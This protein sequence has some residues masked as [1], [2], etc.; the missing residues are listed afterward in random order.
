[1]T[2]I[3]GG[4]WTIA[5]AAALLLGA[6]WLRTGS[7]L[8]LAA[9]AL[10]A[11]WTLATTIHER[12]SPTA[13]GCAAVLLVFALL[14]G[15]DVRRQARFA[16]DAAATRTAL[17]QRATTDLAGELGREADRLR[18]LAVRALDAPADA[19]AAFGA[20]D[21]MRGDN[22][23]RSVVLARGG[24][25]TAWS[26]QYLAPV[27]SLPG[28]VGVVASEFY[29]VL[30]AIAGRGR[31]RAVAATL[32]HAVRPAD[33]LATALDEA[34][35]VSS[36]VAGFVYGGAVPDPR[37]SAA[38]V[39]VGGVPV[40]SVRALALGT[41]ELQQRMA[42]R[43]RE[44]G[45]AALALALVLFLAVT[46]RGGGLRERF[47]ALGVTLV[48]IA[49]MPL[50]ELSNRTSL[51]NP[52]VFFVGAGGPLTASV[53]ALA[54]TSATI[55]VAVLA[56][57]RARLFPTSRWQAAL[58]I[59]T[60]AVLGPFLLSSIARG[61]RFPAT[62]A[63]IVLWLAWETA[64]FLTAVVVLYAGI[65]AGE[66]AVGPRRG[67]PLWV[68]PLFA[69]VATA[70]APLVVAPRGGLPQWYTVLWVLSI[71]TIA[72]ARH[73]RG[74][75]WAAA[76]VA[77][78]GSVTLVWSE[79]VKARVALAE[80]DVAALSVADSSAS[81][82][83]RRFPA[84]LDSL[85]APRTR[86][87]LLARYAASDLA[88]S[89][90]P[91]NV[92]SWTPR[93]EMIADLRV[94][95]GP[96]TARGVE[97]FA[98]SASESMRPTLT[99]EPAEPGVLT[100]LAIPH[101]DRSVTTVVVAPRTRLV[102]PDP[103]PTITGLARARDA[104]GA[105]PYTLQFGP[106]NASEFVTTAVQW[107][108][109]K[110]ELHGDWFLTPVGGRVMHVHARVPLAGYGALATR[111]ALMACVN[112]GLLGFLWLLLVV[113]DGGAVLRAREQ[114]RTWIRSY[115]ARLTLSLFAAF[116]LPAGAFASWSYSRLQSEAT[117]ARDLLVRETLRGVTA[118][119]GASL[120][121]LS[122][123]FD[124]PLFLFADGV[125]VA[126]S[127]PLFDALAPM[128]KLL[129]SAAQQD[130]L[131]GDD[132]FATTNLVVAGE[133]M[134]FGFR[135]VSDTSATANLVLAA[136]ARTAELT[137]DPRR[138]DLAFFVLFATVVGALG[139]LFIS[140][141]AGRTFSRPIGSLREGALALAAGD[142]EPQLAG[143]PPPEFEPVFKAF[144]QMARDLQAGR[145]RDARAQRVLAWGEMAR[146]VA[147]EIKNPLT[148]M[149][150]G[151]QY[152]QRA[153]DDPRVDFRAAFDENAERLL[154]EI[155]RLDEIARAFSRYGTAPDAQPAAEPVDVAEAV[156]DVVRLEQLGADG[157]TWEMRG[158]DTPTHA[159]ARPSE[160]RE[161]LLNLLENARLADAARVTAVVD[162]RDGRV[163]IVVRDDGHGIAADVLSRIFEPHFSTRT[164]GSGL[165]LAISRRLI[166][167]WGGSIQVESAPGAGTA[168]TISLVPAP[169]G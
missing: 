105:A 9:L 109:Q 167:G 162:M 164:S 16:G 100:V 61:I 166:D 7:T 117:E 36:D 63:P 93:G 121:T 22:P 19:A 163:R 103:F 118:Q 64:V 150:L 111:G 141:V 99:H 87:E 169:P 12:R 18:A 90:F 129:P 79:T 27:D 101:R 29:L 126:T 42:E 6:G 154:I 165:G 140:G 1:M 137:L 81:A 160:L 159:M 50:A 104:G 71:V 2:P 120:D 5:A 136:P 114:A 135:V 46:W 125:L 52:A 80:Q 142:R 76:T 92:T 74:S 147:H 153:K 156:R 168:M 161:V 84:Q 28:P 115:R 102:T 66:A 47:G 146:Q 138:R 82:L 94:G 13:A 124:T 132:G 85:S 116:M 62:G 37:D 51:F 131:A 23:S 112:L 3:R 55:L 148:P 21:A 11:L 77:A 48:V 91:V 134:R 14:D 158:A 4:R 155:D 73:G 35:A 31:D 98:R 20:L 86:V 106:A 78:F 17:E 145:A 88:S 130:L 60:V 24:L 89:D 144:R 33:A 40:L 56:T 30:Y 157:V 65:A 8:L 69:A 39:S 149:R 143:D 122:A 38:V 54:L 10:A 15:L 152:L 110:E 58:V 59:V 49:T 44:R 107:S 151:V 119:Q 67:L 96:G 25:L 95:M 113:A 83:V 68:A 45:A 72:V 32:V 139:A 43:G 108:R 34:A 53:A 128:G 75:L 97:V 133:P 123:R 70:I 57:Q 41:P 127:D 26:G